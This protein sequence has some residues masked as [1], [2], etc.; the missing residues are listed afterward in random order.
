MK[1]KTEFKRWCAERGLTARSI[2]E[3]TGIS[4]HTIWHYMQ[5]TRHP[6]RRSA[7]KL[8]EVYGVNSRELFPL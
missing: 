1:E 4:H 7:K 2:S 5:G 6:S 3:D 8:E